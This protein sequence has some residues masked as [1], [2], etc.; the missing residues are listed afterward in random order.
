MNKHIFYLSVILMLASTIIYL[1]TGDRSFSPIF[2]AGG[3]FGI[4][5]SLMGFSIASALTN[6]R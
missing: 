3:V 5:V 6:K 4:G 2:L 1:L